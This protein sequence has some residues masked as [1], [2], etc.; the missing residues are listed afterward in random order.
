MLIIF[1]GSDAFQIVPLNGKEWGISIGLGAIS[2][3]FG[4][5]IRLFPDA[6]VSAMIPKFMHRKWTTEP[7]LDEV[8]KQDIEDF[9][10]PLRVMSAL[11]GPK[12]RRHSGFRGTLHDAKAKAKEKVHHNGSVDEKLAIQE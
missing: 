11:R 1:V 8:E 3:P 9:K 6:W 5:L 7:I 4:A 10:P 2:L 12:V